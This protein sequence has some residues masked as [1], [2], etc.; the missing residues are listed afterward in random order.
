[1]T[2][3]PCDHHGFHSA[4]TRYHRRAG[5]LRFVLVCD[6]CGRE[7]EEVTRIAYRPHFASHRTPRLAA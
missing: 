2:T 4:T 7:V 6:R 5:V 1:M 3:V